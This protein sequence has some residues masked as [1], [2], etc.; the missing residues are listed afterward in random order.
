MTSDSKE[1][2]IKC[3]KCG[4]TI[5]TVA[6]TR[7]I[8]ECIKRIRACACGARFVTVEKFEKLTKKYEPTTTDSSEQ[9]TA[10]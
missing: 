7:R 6:E 1:A 8:P 4:A 9:E 5:C 3:P 10:Y 2:G